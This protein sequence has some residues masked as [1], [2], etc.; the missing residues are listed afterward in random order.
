MSNVHSLFISVVLQG[1]GAR[2]PWTVELVKR[3]NDQEGEWKRVKGG[4]VKGGEGL[5]KKGMCWSGMRGNGWVGGCQGGSKGGNLNIS[6]TSLFTF[7]PVSNS[8]T[9]TINYLHII[10]TNYA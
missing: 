4:D 10:C 6:L 9:K 3:G 8:C 5:D 2:G 7:R 1:K